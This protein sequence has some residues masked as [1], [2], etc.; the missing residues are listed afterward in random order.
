MTSL[1]QKAPIAML[2][3]VNRAD[4]GFNQI[5]LGPFKPGHDRLKISP[6]AIRHEVRRDLRKRVN[7]FGFGQRILRLWS[8]DSKC[9]STSRPTRP[10]FLNRA[11][12]VG[13]TADS[14]R[15]RCSEVCSSVSRYIS[16]V[17]AANVRD[18][19]FFCSAGKVKNETDDMNQDF[20]WKVE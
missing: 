18:L 9:I 15:S 17:S 12:G 7:V 11:C 5:C 8:Q 6:G 19:V 10:R 13:I 16:R 3:C 20:C 2:L 1:S 4:G 14:R